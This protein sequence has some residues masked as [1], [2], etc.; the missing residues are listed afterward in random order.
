M[1]RGYV[2]PKPARIT[3]AAQRATDPV[4]TCAQSKVGKEAEA[5]PLLCRPAITQ[6]VTSPCSPQHPAPCTL[7]PAP[8]T[9]HPAPCTRINPCSLFWYPTPPQHHAL[10]GPTKLLPTVSASIR[11]PVTSSNWTLQPTYMQLLLSLHL[12][13]LRCLFADA[14]LQG[15]DGG[16]G[17]AGLQGL[18][19]LLCLGHTGTQCCLLLLQCTQLGIER[20]GGDRGGVEGG[21]LGARSGAPAR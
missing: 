12:L 8:C 18:Q 1:G 19:L 4:S 2:R 20:V 13:Q 3:T 21:G 17:A 14:D 15:F 10:Q 11:H 9:L 7:H 6:V 16:G 5:T